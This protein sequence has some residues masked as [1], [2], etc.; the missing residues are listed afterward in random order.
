M[1]KAPDA[2]GYRP[3][4]GIVKYRTGQAIS[5]LL[6][7]IPDLNALIDALICKKFQ[8]CSQESIHDMCLICRDNFANDDRVS[9]LPCK[10]IYHEYCYNHSKRCP[11]CRRRA[12]IVKK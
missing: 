5:D 9:V 1:M 10:H 12:Y 8:T 2:N 4:K 3:V 6:L 11:Y 7:A